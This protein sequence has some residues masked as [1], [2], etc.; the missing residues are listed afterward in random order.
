MSEPRD[1]NIRR[2]TLETYSSLVRTE[3]R[4]LSQNLVSLAEK[5]SHFTEDFDAVL[6]Q[7]EELSTQVDSMQSGLEYCRSEL[8][9]VKK[10]IS[11]QAAVIQALK[12]ESTSVP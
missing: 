8:A 5:V 10:Q 4:S 7:L 12:R 3:V 9:E 11:A 6:M 2:D 1:H